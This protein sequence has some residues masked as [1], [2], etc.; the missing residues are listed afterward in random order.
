MSVES[1]IYIYIYILLLLLL[2][3]YIYTI[4]LFFVFRTSPTPHKYPHMFVCLR[5]LSTPRNVRLS[6][7]CVSASGCKGAAMEASPHQPRADTDAE[8]LGGAEA[9]TPTHAQPT[10]TPNS[11]EKQSGSQSKSNRALKSVI[12]ADRRARVLRMEAVLQRE[13]AERQ[14]RKAFLAAN[15]SPEAAAIL[16]AVDRREL[17]LAAR[18]AAVAEKEIVLRAA[19]AQSLQL[20]QH[21]E[22]YRQ[23]EHALVAQST[24]PALLQ[25]PTDPSV[26]AVAA[27][28]AGAGTVVP[29]LDP[30]DMFRRWG[31]LGGRPR[32]GQ[33]TGRAAGLKKNCREKGAPI[34]RRDPDARERLHIIAETRKLIATH[35]GEG[36]QVARI[37]EKRFGFS[38]EF[39]S[40]LFRR[41]KAYAR[42]LLASRCGFKG[43]NPFASDLRLDLVS[44]QQGRLVGGRR[45]CKESSGA[46]LRVRESE[47]QN[48]LLPVYKKIKDWADREESNGHE[49]RTR[50]IMTRALLQLKCAAS[51]QEVL[52]ELRPNLYNKKLHDACIHRIGQLQ[53]PTEHKKALEHWRDEQLLPRTVGPRVKAQKQGAQ[54]DAQI[55]ASWLTTCRTMDRAMHVAYLGQA[56]HLAAYVAD[57]AS[58]IEHKR[59]VVITGYDAS[60]IWVQLRCEEA[61]FRSQTEALQ[62]ACRR[63][64]SSKTFDYVQ[65]TCKGPTLTH[66]SDLLL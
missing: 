3:I 45:G 17:A 41:E 52:Q 63:R 37:I 59:E 58:W 64:H 34:K 8:V 39:V 25:T 30:S 65:A 15:H 1:N 35:E 44:H 2:Y 27:S 18:E 20:R 19:V 55:R 60:P 24:M 40:A 12:D 28:E 16:T 13:V 49:V 31:S 22:I 62:V 50:H 56:E 47:L 21:E 36:S 14:S 26:A 66:D 33:T 6:L 42:F 38:W 54:A 7:Y 57:P 5:A 61:K 11:E 48:P 9:K 32:T 43:V 4:I 29:V 53:K 51:Y 46:R 23:V 10:R